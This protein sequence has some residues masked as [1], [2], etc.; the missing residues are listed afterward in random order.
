M[1]VDGMITCPCGSQAA[2]KNGIMHRHTA[3]CGVICQSG[4]YV[5]DA[6]TTAQIKSGAI[7]LHTVPWDDEEDGHEHGECPNG[8][9]LRCCKD[10]E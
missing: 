2:I 3:P 5:G 7:R 6:E 8:C 10:A 1:F 4:S 9:F